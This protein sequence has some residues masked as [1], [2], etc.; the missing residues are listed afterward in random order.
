MCLLVAFINVDRQRHTVIVSYDDDDRKIATT[1]T[2]F[3]IIPIHFHTYTTHKILH[4]RFFIDPSVY[5]L[6]LTTVYT[7]IVNELFICGHAHPPP[8]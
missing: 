7:L 6:S 3:V 1:T 4:N 8:L 5:S 2:T